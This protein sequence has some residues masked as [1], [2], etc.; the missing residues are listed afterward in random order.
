MPVPL[1]GDAADTFFQTASGQFAATRGA[2]L[3]FVRKTGIKLAGETAEERSWTLD[4]GGGELRI[5]LAP[6]CGGKAS[7]ALVRVEGA[8]AASAPLDSFAASLR[9]EGVGAACI[10]LQ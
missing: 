3:T 6:W 2:R 8:G 4:E 7:L 9:P 1:A 5:A 10:D